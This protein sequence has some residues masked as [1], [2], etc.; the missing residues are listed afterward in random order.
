M[1]KGKPSP[2]SPKR[3]GKA[4]GLAL[5][6]PAKRTR[7]RPPGIGTYKPTE[8]E[9][10]LVE[11]MASIGVPRP[12]MCLLLPSR[13]KSKNSEMPNISI[14][15]LLKYY[16]EELLKGKLKTHVQVLNS[17]YKNCVGTDETPGNVTAQI[18][19]TKTQLGWRETLALV[20]GQPADT[21][22]E[23]EVTGQLEAARRVAFTLALG[24][25]AA[26]AEK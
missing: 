17:F 20:P 9:R 18:W 11:R 6:A 21:P 12:D 25:R 26:K 24:A 5:P 2:R 13:Q 10:T 14:N 1:P 16:P 7:R 23:I 8:Q 22:A 15:T 3:A 19:Y 4:K